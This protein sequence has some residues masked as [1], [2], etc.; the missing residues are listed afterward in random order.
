LDRD[1]D[2]TLD[3]SPAT[4]REL[5]STCQGI[6]MGVLTLDLAFFLL[7]TFAAALVAGLAG[8]AFGLVAA[9]V[10]LHILTPVQTASLIIAFGLIVQGVAVWK[11]RRAL[12][13]TRLW[14]FLVGGVLGVP[15][16]VAVLGWANPDY[17]RASVGVLLIVYSIH[18]LARTAVKPLVAGGAR[19]DAGVGLLNGI[20]GGATGLAGIIV[21]IWC[22]L[23]GWPKDVQRTVFQPVGV[24]VFAMSALWLG[25]SGAVNADTIRL[26]LIGVPVLLA[27]T[28]LG[29]RLYGRVDDA[30]FR[31][32]V[33]PCC[34]R[35][36]FSLRQTGLVQWSTR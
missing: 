10:W 36:V 33:L 2:P 7:A 18:G 23:R 32:I 31:K 30:G 25:A 17:M 5:I 21:T 27:G 4:E 22:G 24:A 3:R 12:Q 15:L 16:G 14:P 26:F 20:L 11:L 29:L 28:W 9:A 35:Q 13:W 8:F 34:W 6:A 19:A 1:G